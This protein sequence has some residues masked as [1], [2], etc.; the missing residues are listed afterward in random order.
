MRELIA[1]HAKSHTRL[2]L[3][4]LLRVAPTDAES[5]FRLRNL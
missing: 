3:L 4:L 1:K 5:R 2:L